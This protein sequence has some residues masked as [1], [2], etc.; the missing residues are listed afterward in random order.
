MNYPM[1]YRDMN[2]VDPVLVG[3]WLLAFVAL[4]VLVMALIVLI[5]GSTDE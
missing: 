3:V 4:A 5:W 2:P 1:I